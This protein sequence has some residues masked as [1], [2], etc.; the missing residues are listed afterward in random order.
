M[1]FKLYQMDVKSVFLNGVIQEEVYVRQ[2][3]SFKNPKYPDR[4]YKLLKALYELKQ[5]PWAW[6]ARLKTFLLEHVYV[7]GSVDKTLITLNHGTDFLLVQ[8]YVNDIIF[9]GSSH[10]LVSRFQEMMESE[11]QMSMMGEL[12]FFLGIQVKQTKQGTFV[13]QDKYTK[14]LMKKFNMPELKPLSTSVSSATS[15]GPDEDGEAVDQREY[16]S[17]VLGFYTKT[18]YSS[19]A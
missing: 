8:I 5:A 14:D 17:V 9:G 2:P 7:M 11:F 1:G 10:T 18:K 4:V 19:Y 15:L 12:T 6:Y 13:H 16:R 3:L